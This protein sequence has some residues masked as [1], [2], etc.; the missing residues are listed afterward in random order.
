MTGE[1]EAAEKT[2]L[3]IFVH[4][5]QYQNLFFVKIYGIQKDY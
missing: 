2:L 3:L 5:S 4:L 1:A